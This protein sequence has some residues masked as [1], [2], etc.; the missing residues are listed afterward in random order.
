MERVLVASSVRKRPRGGHQRQESASYCRLIREL[1]RLSS[2][3]RCT[4]K[5]IHNYGD[6]TVSGSRP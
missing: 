4:D 3:V 6:C 2:G 5:C 1:E